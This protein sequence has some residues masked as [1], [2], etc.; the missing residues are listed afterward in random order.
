MKKGHCSYTYENT[1]NSVAAVK[2]VDDT[3]LVVKR[4]ILDDTI[5]MTKY[6]CCHLGLNIARRN[7]KDATYRREKVALLCSNLVRSLSI[8]G[9]LI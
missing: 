2:F 4:Y 1:H 8:L 9:K 5:N 3:K 7:L 6:T